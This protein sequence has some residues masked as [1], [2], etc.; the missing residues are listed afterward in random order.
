MDISHTMLF[1]NIFYIRK[2]ISEH[3]TKGTA[4]E[5]SLPLFISER[6]QSGIQSDNK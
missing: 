1:E 5:E 2:P 4:V 6:K 3:F